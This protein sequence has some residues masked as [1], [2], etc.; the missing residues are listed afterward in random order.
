MAI[1]AWYMDDSDADQREAHRKSPNE[2]CDIQTLTKLGVLSWELD[3]DNHETDP[4]LAEIRKERNYSYLDIISV[5]KATLPNYEEKIRSFYHEHLHTDEEIRYLLDGSGYFDVRDSQDRWIRI[6]MKKGDM[7]VLPA[8]IY[9]RFTL[10]SNN[11]T[12]AMR[13][14]VGEPVWTPHNRPMDD[15]PVR[16]NYVQQFYVEA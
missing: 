9:H 8:G 10:D 1:E 13:L 3:A 6:A 4:V 14:F 2:P 15:H 12:K 5:S 11:Y 7:I 16:K